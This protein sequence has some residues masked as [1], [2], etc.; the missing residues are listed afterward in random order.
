M[1]TTVISFYIAKYT[2][3]FSTKKEYGKVKDFLIEVVG[4]LILCSI[5]L[6]YVVLVFSSRIANWLHIENTS[7]IVLAIILATITLVSSLFTGA[8][9]GMQKFILYGCFCLIGPIFKIIAVICS[10]TTTDK[11]E[12]ILFVWII[13]TLVSYVIGYIFI[14]KNLSDYKREK[15]LISYY[16]KKN[17]IIKLFISNIGMVLLNNIDMLLVKH[18]FNNEAGL[19]SSALMLGKIVTYFSGTFIIVLFPMVADN[20]D[21]EESKKL[22]KKSIKYNVILTGIVICILCLFADLIIKLLLGS[23]YL[24]CK[25]YLYSLSFYVVPLSIVSI[26]ANFSMARNRM[27]IITISMLIGSCF[28]ILGGLFFIDDL[29][30]FIIYNGIVMWFIVFLNMYVIKKGRV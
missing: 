3:V 16:E 29:N 7:I 17:Y 12:I 6:A 8:L 19:Y 15:N 13:G 11:I 30:Y 24:S 14:F 28:E 20:Q 18:N 21:K 9:Q 23:T 2:A 25:S 10:L 26:L 1:P 5:F 4:L 27:K 22:L